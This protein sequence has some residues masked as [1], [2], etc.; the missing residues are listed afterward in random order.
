MLIHLVLICVPYMCTTKHV[1]AHGCSCLT[2]SLV[3]TD[4]VLNDSATIFFI[5]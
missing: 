5:M 2:T 3:V 1:H 4:Q